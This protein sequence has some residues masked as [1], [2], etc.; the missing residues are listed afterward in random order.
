M[1]EYLGPAVEAEIAYR[2]ERARE[3]FRPAPARHHPRR[4][5]WIA[6]R[7]RSRRATG[8]P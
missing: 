1:S 6:L 5:A 2:Q 8:R 7:S 4:S 3:D